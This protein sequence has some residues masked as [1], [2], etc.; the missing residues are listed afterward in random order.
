V[1]LNKSGGLCTVNKISAEF[2]IPVRLGLP[3]TPSLIA[4]EK[5]MAEQVSYYFPVSPFIKEAAAIRK[6]LQAHPQLQSDPEQYT[7][8]WQKENLFCFR[9]SL[10]KNARI[11]SDSFFVIFGRYPV[12]N[13]DNPSTPDSSYRYTVFWD[14]EPEK[15]NLHYSRKDFNRIVKELRFFFGF[16][17][18]EQEGGSKKKKRSETCTMYPSQQYSPSLT[19]HWEKISGK[20]YRIS[21][22]FH[23]WTLN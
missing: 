10:F 17:E 20:G 4:Q 23:L 22:T 14:Y 7:Q 3:I 6:A 1:P 11:P 2:F 5:Q 21:M 15:E 16:V 9:S 18:F 13:P 8:E 12:F 19:I